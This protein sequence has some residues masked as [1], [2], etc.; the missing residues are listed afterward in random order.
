MSSYSKL[1]VDF[2]ERVKRPRP[3]NGIGYPYQISAK[4]LMDNFHYLEDHGGLPAGTA[5]DMLYH[6]GSAWVVL[7]AD[8]AAPSGTINILTQDGTA[9]PVWSN[10]TIVTVDLCSGSGTTS[11]N[12]ISL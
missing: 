4:D 9:M 11:H 5:G 6:D 12:F 8:T 7:Y 2:E 10:K 1:P 3:A